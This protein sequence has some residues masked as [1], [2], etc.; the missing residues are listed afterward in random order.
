MFH[1]AKIFYGRKINTI[2]M[3]LTKVNTENCVCTFSSSFFFFAA[4]K[5]WYLGDDKGHFWMYIKLACQRHDLKSC[6]TNIDNIENIKS[7]VAKVKIV[8]MMGIITL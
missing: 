6:I 4:S 7:P 8:L 1:A 5:T 2:I 3:I